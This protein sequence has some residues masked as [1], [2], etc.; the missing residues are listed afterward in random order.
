[1]TITVQPWNEPHAY[2]LRSALHAAVGGYKSALE[3]VRQLEAAVEERDAAAAVEEVR[4]LRR[5]IVSERV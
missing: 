4:M 5:P 2:A 1:M 3:R